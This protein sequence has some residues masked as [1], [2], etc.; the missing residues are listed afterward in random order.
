M[1]ENKFAN[2]KNKWYTPPRPIY[3][4]EEEYLESK[5]YVI[6]LT[7]TL[8]S[9]NGYD[10][11]SALSAFYKS[12]DVY[13]DLSDWKNNGNF[14][15]SNNCYD[16]LCEELG[17]QPIGYDFAKIGNKK[18]LQQ[19]R[20]VLEL[21]QKRLAQNKQGFEFFVEDAETIQKEIRERGLN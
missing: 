14:L 10:F 13:D 12:E 16:S 18:I 8:L 2:F 1:I 19:I 3:D 17:I 21:E 4:L 9:Q 7:A 11:Y 6:A 20:F 15:T 5:A